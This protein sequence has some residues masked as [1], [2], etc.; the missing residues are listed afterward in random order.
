MKKNHKNN[1]H[2]KNH[3]KK[4]SNGEIGIKFMLS[5]LEDEYRKANISEKDYKA[6][7]EKYSKRIGGNDM[8]KKDKGKKE[9]EIE[10]I[11][12]EVIEKG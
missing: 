11:T 3:K 6:L 7:K 2:K 10:E 5:Q 8:A 12:P 9:E 4:N 1:N